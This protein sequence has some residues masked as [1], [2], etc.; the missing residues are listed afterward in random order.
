MTAMT[1]HDGGD[2]AYLSMTAH[3]EVRRQFY[4]ATTA[5]TG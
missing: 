3:I 4:L 1:A 5:L 2:G